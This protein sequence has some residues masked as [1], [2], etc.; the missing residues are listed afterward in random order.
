[1]C[2]EPKLEMRGNDSIGRS[3]NPIRFAE[4]LFWHLCKLR[5]S[6]K[7]SRASKYVRGGFRH[8]AIVAIGSLFG[9]CSII[10]VVQRDGALNIE[11]SFGM[12]SIQVCP[13]NDG[14]VTSLTSFGIAFTPLGKTIGFAKETLALLPGSC[15]VA[16]W[17]N[18]ERQL[19][20]FESLVGPLKEICI[21][22]SSEEGVSK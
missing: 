4:V 16:M 20:R 12:V 7:Q 22:N 17:I 19:S 18:D 11:R 21:V 9:A 13:K 5:I 8:T 1:M 3:S 2:I 15:K 6:E 10:Q 14:L